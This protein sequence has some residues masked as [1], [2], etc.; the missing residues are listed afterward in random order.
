[1]RPAEIGKVL[2]ALAFFVVFF[3]VTFDVGMG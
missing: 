1:M 3:L 2:L